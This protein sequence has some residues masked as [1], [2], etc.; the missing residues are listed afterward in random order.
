MANIVFKF[1]VYREYQQSICDMKLTIS[2]I[3]HRFSFSNL[4]VSSKRTK[5][6]TLYEINFNGSTFLFCRSLPVSLLICMTMLSLVEP[7][8]MVMSIQRQALELILLAANRLQIILLITLLM[9]L[10]AIFLSNGSSCML[11]I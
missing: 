5:S 1:K 11:E 7:P 2:S 8:L 3:S 6:S 9:V 10:L 4:N